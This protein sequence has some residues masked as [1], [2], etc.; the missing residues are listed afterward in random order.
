MKENFSTDF[1]VTLTRAIRT[2]PSLR[3]KV[4]DNVR[5]VRADPAVGRP[6]RATAAPE[7][8]RMYM[9]GT[10]AIVYGIAR[11]GDEDTLAFY[12]LEPIGF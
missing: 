10:W 2:R 12:D 5:H 4:L 6:T 3:G 1:F 8:A 11:T 7:G 9:C